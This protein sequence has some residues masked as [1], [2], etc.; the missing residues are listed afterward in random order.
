M[1]E[2]DYRP[3]SV[4]ARAGHRP[5]ADARRGELRH[6]ALR[7]GLDAV[8]RSSAPRT[9][10]ATSSPSSAS[11]RSTARR[12]SSAVERLRLP[13]RRRDPRDRPAGGAG[14]R[15]SSRSPPAIAAGGGRG[16]AATTRSPSSPS[17][18]SRAP[19]S[20]RGTCSSSAT[21]TVVA[22]RRAGR[23]ASRPPAHRR[24]ALDARGRRRRVPPG[25]CVG[26]WSPRS[27]YELGHAAD[28][29]DDVDARSS[30]PTT[31]WRSARC[32]RC[33]R[34]AARSR[35]E[36]SVVGFDD[37]PEAQYFTPP[38]TTVRQDFAEI[39]RRSLRLMLEMIESGDEGPSSPPMVG[40]ELIVRSSTAPA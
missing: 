29:R 13:G 32:A 14:A 10:P 22:H 3:N 17:T 6:D 26:D 7:A 15:R 23:L 35:G 25:R 40:P 37:I 30:S 16:R 21:A 38:L 33:T 4:G 31:R 39:G 12:C 2:L 5:L 24:L 11:R 18:S 28:R 36:V 27:G 20:P 9:R 8:R 1:R 34:P 19:R